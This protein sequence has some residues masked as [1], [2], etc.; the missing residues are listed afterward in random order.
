[1]RQTDNQFGLLEKLFEAHL[2]PIKEDIREMKEKG[3]VAHLH[4]DNAH[5]RIDKYE[6]RFWGW[7]AGVGISSSAIGAWLVKNIPALFN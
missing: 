3:A 2:G 6:N 1:M 7:L 4:A 5:K